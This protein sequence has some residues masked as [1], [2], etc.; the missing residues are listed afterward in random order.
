MLVSVQFADHQISIGGVLYKTVGVDSFK[1]T[2][3]ED[4]DPVG[5]EEVKRRRQA[6]LDMYVTDGLPYHSTADVVMSTPKEEMAPFEPWHY[7]N[8]DVAVLCVDSLN[9]YLRVR[10]LMSEMKLNLASGDSV[11][12]PAGT[13]IQ[14]VGYGKIMRFGN[15]PG[16]WTPIYKKDNICQSM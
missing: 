10:S 11:F 2:L 3:N 13:W 8:V 6:V 16:A 9:S 1:W 15:A 7:Y 14:Y 5:I 4:T 12:I